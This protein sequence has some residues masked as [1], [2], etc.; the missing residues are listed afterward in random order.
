MYSL[1]DT[2]LQKYSYWYD[3][4]YNLGLNK[5]I[6]SL[7]IHDSNILICEGLF[8][9]EILKYVKDN[10][11]LIFY[12]AEHP[13]GFVS[14]EFVE[15]QIDIINKA[16][17]VYTICPFSAKWLNSLLNIDKFKPIFL[18]TDLD[19]APSIKSEHKHYDV[20]Y[21]GH[22]SP[23]TSTFLKP[24]FDFKYAWLSGNIHPN[25]T[26]SNLS[27]ADKLKLVSQSKISITHNILNFSSAGANVVRSIPNWHLNEAFSELTDGGSMTGPQI[28][29]RVFEAALCE[30]LILCKRDRWNTIENFFEP[31]VD[32]LYYES[33]DDLGYVIKNILNNYEDYQF[34]T[35]NAK[36]KVVEKYSTLEF[37]KIIYTE[38]VKQ[39]M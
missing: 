25:V 27:Y 11:Q 39:T 18:P 34:M 10:L 1:T 24:I 28:K 37:L 3:P 30:T 23:Q 36:R 5:H 31:D 7:G 14:P 32:F 35:K 15:R 2:F 6:K 21:T 9:L 13:N 8:N 4:I 38:N 17:R 16:T 26:H 29:T 22:A 20:I 33:D 12:E 19:L